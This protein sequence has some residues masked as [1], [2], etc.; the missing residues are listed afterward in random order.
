[1]IEG[2]SKYD[3][4]FLRRRIDDGSGQQLHHG[5]LR[6]KTN[7]LPMPPLPP[8]H[9]SSS[10]SV[11]APAS[12]PVAQ[13]LTIATQQTGASPLSSP[14]Q[15]SPALSSPRAGADAVPA[16]IQRPTDNGAA[17]DRAI[18]VPVE[19]PRC[20]KDSLHFEYFSAYLL[21]GFT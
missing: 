13:V 19:K 21:N 2:N 20:Q 10:S 9:G 5:G 1:M 17:L 8:K 4:R 12:A 7:P 18:P 16:S 15:S 11:H 14:A 6:K 3:L